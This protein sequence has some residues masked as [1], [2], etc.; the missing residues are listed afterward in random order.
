[1][2]SEDLNQILKYRVPGI[3][4]ALHSALKG[5]VKKNVGLHV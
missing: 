1:M 2:P 5:E 4:Q 3:D